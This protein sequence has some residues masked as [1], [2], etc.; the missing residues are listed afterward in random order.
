MHLCTPPFT[1]VSEFSS[2]GQNP[3][4]HPP[5]P[6]RTS[7]GMC[8]VVKC[9]GFW[10]CPYSS[11]SEPS[12]TRSSSGSSSSSTLLASPPEPGSTLCHFLKAFICLCA[13]RTDILD[14]STS[15]RWYVSLLSTLVTMYGP[16]HLLANFR[17]D[18]CWI[19][20]LLS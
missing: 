6:N 12:S 10:I 13:T 18:R 14:P 16:N 19:S 3:P 11:S 7:S 1:P 15:A 5:P 2:C 20:R 8:Q 4:R 9:W 17:I